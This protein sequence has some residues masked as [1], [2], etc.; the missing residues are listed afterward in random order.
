MG[1]RGRSYIRHQLLMM[2]LEHCTAL[3][4]S[5]AWLPETRMLLNTKLKEKLDRAGLG[6]GISR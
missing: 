3:I 4:L 5:M 1:L 2:E 6:G